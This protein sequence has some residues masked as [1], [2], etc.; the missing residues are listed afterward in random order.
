MKQYA[1]LRKIADRAMSG[2]DIRLMSSDSQSKVHTVS[3]SQW[4]EMSDEERRHL[5]ESG[6]I[7][8]V[9]PSGDRLLENFKSW[10]DPWPLDR[11]ISLSAQRFVQGIPIF[12]SS[13]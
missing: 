1:T 4:N 13:L 8:V 6:S 11:F 10:K 2:D 5:F 3:R 7:H 9:G 12:Y